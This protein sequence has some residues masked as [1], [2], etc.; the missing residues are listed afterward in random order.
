MIIGQQRH[1]RPRPR[2]LTGE[3]GASL[4]EYALLVALVAVVCV[5]A[6]AFLGRNTSSTM[7]DGANGIGASTP[8]MS[9]NGAAAYGAWVSQC[10]NGGGTVS[11]TSTVGTT[12][13][14]ACNG[15]SRT[16][17]T[18]AFDTSQP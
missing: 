9:P 14:S 2:R 11:L 10:A 5:G 17:T 8:V 6:V 16:G 1:D 4:V 15:G 12:N 3:V 18:F 13:N 7:D